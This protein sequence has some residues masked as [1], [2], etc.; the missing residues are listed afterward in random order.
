MPAKPRPEVPHPHGFWTPPGM[1]TPPPPLAAWSNAWPLIQER[2]F[3]QFAIQTSPDATWGHCLLS[4]GSLLGRRDHHP[5]HSNLLSGSF[6]K[7]WGFPSAS[8]PPDWT[9]SV[10]SAA[11]HQTCFLDPFTS[12]VALLQTCSSDSASFLY[13]GAH[14]WTQYS[15]YDTTEILLREGAKNLSS[16]IIK[17]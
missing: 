7:W 9:A 13:W 15:K 6:R 1:G 3:S 5:P 16:I 10:P 14:N 8:F 4:Y 2:N 17:N 11:P 12:F